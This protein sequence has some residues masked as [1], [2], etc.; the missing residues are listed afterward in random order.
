ME[1]CSYKNIIP[2][3]QFGFRHKHST[4]H[5]IHELLS[6]INPQL[7]KRESVGATLID[8]EKAFDTVWLDGLIYKL[9]KKKFPEHLIRLV[10][11]MLR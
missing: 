10:N 5:A 4:V 2:N 9:I 6:Y 8:L 1:Q 3:T 11:N 7:H